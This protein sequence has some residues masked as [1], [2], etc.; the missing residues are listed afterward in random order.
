MHQSWHYIYPFQNEQIFAFWPNVCIGFTKPT[1]FHINGIHLKHHQK[2]GTHSPELWI[3]SYFAIFCIEKSN[4]CSC[5]L[6]W[7][8]FIRL[9]WHA[10]TR[11]Q[12]LCKHKLGNLLKTEC[13][14][15]IA[16]TRLFIIR[17]PLRFSIERLYIP[18]LLYLL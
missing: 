7:S 6:D 14:L 3:L 15:C 9:Y 4:F 11:K 1:L 5:L 2:K 8:S 10:I 16:Y 13:V 17:N 12:A 18:N